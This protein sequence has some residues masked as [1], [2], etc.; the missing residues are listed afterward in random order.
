MGKHGESFTELKGRKQRTFFIK[1]NEWLIGKDAEDRRSAYH[2]LL[3]Y[4]SEHIPLVFQDEVFEKAM[5]LFDEIKQG[6]R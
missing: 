1:M 3:V 4:A 5:T 2:C 6:G